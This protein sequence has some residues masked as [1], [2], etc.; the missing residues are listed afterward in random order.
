MARG[1]FAHRTPQATSLAPTR[2][3]VSSAARIKRDQYRVAFKDRPEAAE[4]WKYYRLGLVR[5]GVG[6]LAAACSRARLFIGRIDPDGSGD[7]EPVDDARI[8]AVINGFAGGQ[9]G[10]SQLIERMIIHLQ[11]VGQTFLVRIEDP[12]TGK[13]REVAATA[14]EVERKGNDVRLI[15]DE[16]TRV[17]LTE[18]GVTRIWNPDEV[19]AW[20]PTSTVFSIL[21]ECRQL[22]ALNAH[23]LATADSRLAGA[24]ILTFPES[25]TIASPTQGDR[26]QVLEDADMNALVEAFMTPL[27]D[28]SSAAAVVPVVI[29]VPDESV[30]GIKHITTD[31]PFDAMI[32]DL[33]ETA[34]K[35]IALALDAPPEIVLGIGETNHWNAEAVD[36]QSIRV[37]I[38]PN[39]QTITSALT[40]EWLPYAMEAAGLTYTDDLV[41]WADVSDLTQEPDRSETALELFKI[42]AISNEALLRATGFT[43]SDAPTEDELR[44][45]LMVK[46]AETPQGASMVAAYLGLPVQATDST[47]T[48]TTPAAEEVDA[49]PAQG[50]IEPTAGRPEL[51]TVAAASWDIGRCEM[52]V[53]R[54][55]E[56]AGKRLLTAPVRGQCRNVKPWALHTQLRADVKDLDRIMSGA[57][58]T[59]R[60]LGAPDQVVAT[61]DTYTRGLIATG[62]PHTTYRL[63]TALTTRRTAA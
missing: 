12:D 38:Q 35:N 15:L 42:D 23:I 7:P 49:E 55:L 20:L 60:E 31:T 9:Q 17:P 51:T 8:Q 2:T 39:L 48:T 53:M 37:H 21:D 41:V 26:Q 62:T 13:T 22:R 58:D 40:S 44:H 32:P 29:R 1:R 34:R 11:V 16:K 14:S 24:G 46:L 19:Q 56:L 4:A 10:Q 5:F 50:E 36:S 61:L 43:D 6:W 28:R 33:I 47:T 25:A 54:A 18:D 30:N 63:G 52:A 59:V 27:E 45:Q 57:W 3:I